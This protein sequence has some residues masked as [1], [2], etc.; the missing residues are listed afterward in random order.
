M[1]IL[2]GL[3]GGFGDLMVGTQKER[4]AFDAAQAAQAAAPAAGAAVAGPVGAVAG[5]AAAAK[6]PGVI[7]ALGGPA[8][9]AIG[10]GKA[11]LGGIADAAEKKKQ[12]EIAGYNAQDQGARQMSAAQA[13]GLSNLMQ[14]YQGILR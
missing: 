11:L 14:G 7:G 10:L 5:K 1:G 6:A 3:L 13:A 8:G 4:A 9:I 2:D 12:G